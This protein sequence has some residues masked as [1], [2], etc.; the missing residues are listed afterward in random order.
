MLNC[1]TEKFRFM[2]VILIARTSEQSEK[3]FSRKFFEKLFN[4][5]LSVNGSTPFWRRMCLWKPLWKSI[6][7]HAS[8]G[9]VIIFPFQ[10]NSKRFP[11]AYDAPFFFL[12]FFF[13]LFLVAEL[14]RQLARDSRF[15]QTRFVRSNPSNHAEKKNTKR[16]TNE[17]QTSRGGE[18]PL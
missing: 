3:H 13:F 2:F 18:G 14:L 4:G 1:K 6:S 17:V 10:T 5:A 9:D 16:E 11:T 15:E 8:V 12:S 7:T